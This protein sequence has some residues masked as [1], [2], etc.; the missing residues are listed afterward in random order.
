MTPT[1]PLVELR[2]A[3]AAD[4][5]LCARWGSD[6][7]FCRAAEWSEGV[8]V[9]ERAAFLR[10]L[11]TAPPADLL[12]LSAWCDG[13]LVGYADVQGTEPTRRELGYVIGPSAAWGKGLGLAAAQA[14]V[15]HMFE[16]MGLETV[17]AEA[18]DANVASV[19]ILQ[20]LGMVETGR[21]APSTYLGRPTHYRQFSLDRSAVG[22]APRSTG[23]QS[24]A[25]E[26]C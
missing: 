1:P 26:L 13:V 16:I 22:A 4:A 15:H 20:R 12:R 23:R 25:T 17:W 24:G 19:R 21:G 8:P 10:R 5:E 18:L 2:T 9:A 11:N 3:T 7:L 6:D 14:G